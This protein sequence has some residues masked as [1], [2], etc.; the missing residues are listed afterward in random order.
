VG[1]YLIESVAFTGS[2][3][4]LRTGSDVGIAYLARNP[5]TLKS[6][7]IAKQAIARQAHPSAREVKGDLEGVAFQGVVSPDRRVCSYLASVKKMVLVA[8]SLY[9]LGQMVKTAQSKI[10]SLATSEEYLFFRTRYP[11]GAEQE[12]A[13]LIL[14]DATIRRWCGPRWRILSARRTWAAAVMAELQAANLPGLV[15]GKIQSGP[16]ASSFSLPDAGEFRLTPEGVTS[17]VY[18]TMEFQTPIAELPLT[19]VTQSEA[20]DY[21]QWRNRYQ[22]NW[23]QYFDP[24]AVRFS[25]RRSQIGMDLTVM[26]LILGTDYRNYIEISRGA[27]IA[28]SAAD[29]HTNA[30][31][32]LVMAVNSDSPRVKEWGG[33]LGSSARSPLL[34]ANPLGWLGHSVGFYFDEDPFLKELGQSTNSQLTLQH[35]FYRVPLAFW[36]EIKNPLGAGAFLTALRWQLDT[37]MPGIMTWENV[38]YNGHTYVKIRRSDSAPEYDPL[39]HLAIYYVLKPQTLT[40]TLNESMIKRAI[41]RL[42]ERAQ[43]S[44]EKKAPL[45]EIR[46]WL[47]ESLSIQADERSL[48][49]IQ[50]ITRDEMSDTLQRLSWD[51]LPILNEWHRLCSNQDP[52]AVHE[53][54]WQTRLVCPAGGTYVWNAEWQTMESTVTGFPGQPRKVAANR[55]VLHNVKAINLGVTF[56]NQGLRAK[57]VFD[58]ELKKP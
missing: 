24:I 25:V 16:V 2:D 45:S 27:K 8:N 43:S 29:P 49:I 54:F 22:A 33:I 23:R 38:D 53:K 51:N 11:L 46:P 44:P 58:R 30:I 9:Q 21:N 1:P 19:T 57:A 35:E 40:M 15:E 50:A 26:P 7:L 32:S 13:F 28:A 10:T 3:P 5:D 14:S 17:S 4:Y 6:L 18:G 52:V 12:S 36:F 34:Q 48:D 55:F 47:G 56:A 37:T 31:L 41:D 42:S 20:N 39:I